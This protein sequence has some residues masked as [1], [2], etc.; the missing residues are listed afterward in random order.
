MVACEAAMVATY[1]G[2][3]NRVGNG[4]GVFFL[5]C[6]VTF[7]ATCVDPISYVYCAEIFPTKFR[8][9]GMAV[10]VTGLFAMNLGEC[11]RLI[12]PPQGLIELH[13]LHPDRH[14]C[15]RQHRLEVLPGLHHRSFALRTCHLEDMSGD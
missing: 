14:S 6:F 9:Q 8:A 3:G 7:Y 4:F 15:I 11:I 12:S 10:S 5:F 2:T 1:G 13:S